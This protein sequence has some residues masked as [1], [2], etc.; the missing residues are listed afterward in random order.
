M[1]YVCRGCGFRA[2]KADVAR[3]HFAPDHE[4]R[5]MVPMFVRRRAMDR[6]PALESA[7]TELGCIIG[8]VGPDAHPDQGWRDVVALDCP[9]GNVERTAYGLIREYQS[10]SEGEF[11]LTGIEYDRMPIRLC[12]TDDGQLFI[13]AFNEGGHNFTQVDLM[14]VISWLRTNR[15]ELIS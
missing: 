4:I 3:A 1:N 13:T 2:D 15:P 6:W 9:H 5:A 14:A 7:L 11:E 12:P 8:A 10:W